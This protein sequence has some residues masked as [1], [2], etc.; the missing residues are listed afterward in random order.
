M[1]AK[2]QIIEQPVVS[3]KSPVRAIKINWYQKYDSVP[4]KSFSDLRKLLDII[5][6]ESIVCEKNFHLIATPART[7]WNEHQD[8]EVHLIVTKYKVD[9][10]C[11][12]K[13][14]HFVLLTNIGSGIGPIV[15]LA[16]VDENYKEDN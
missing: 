3:R 6:P 5:Q 1:K 2:Q 15:H 7:F 9:V 4:L 14:S 13:Y 10:I 12:P 11:N 16:R 8:G